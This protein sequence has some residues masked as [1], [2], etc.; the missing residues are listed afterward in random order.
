MFFI[1]S[2]TEMKCLLWKKC[3]QS[4]Y[5]TLC[6]VQ[7]FQGKFLFT[8]MRSNFDGFNHVVL[9]RFGGR[10][11]GEHA[12]K[13]KCLGYTTTCWCILVPLFI[14]VWLICLKNLQWHSAVF[15]QSCQQ[16]RPYLFK[17]CDRTKTKV[18]HFLRPVVNVTQVQPC[19]G[20]NSTLLSYMM[21]V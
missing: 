19:K 11:D 14:C 16:N 3:I 2:I 12:K 8:L 10:R 7:H 15:C 18:K 1:N 4:G 13:V 17:A 20:S 9:G 21:C 6:L 5:C